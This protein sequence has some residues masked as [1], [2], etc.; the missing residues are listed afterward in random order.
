MAT[1]C[2]KCDVTTLVGMRDLCPK[3]KLEWLKYEAETAQNKYLEELKRQSRKGT[4]ELSS[5]RTS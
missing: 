3:H 4:D 1:G 2:P 5:S